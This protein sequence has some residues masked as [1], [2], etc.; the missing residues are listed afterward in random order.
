MM[1]DELDDDEQALRQYDRAVREHQRAQTWEDHNTGAQ[2]DP[3]PSFDE[4]VKGPQDEDTA[5]DA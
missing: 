2:L 1:R 4:W 5:D 3:M